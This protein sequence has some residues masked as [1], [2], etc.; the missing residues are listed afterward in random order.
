MC[1]DDGIIVDDIIQWKQQNFNPC[2]TSFYIQRNINIGVACEWRQLK[3]DKYDMIRFIDKKIQ[4]QKAGEWLK[5]FKGVSIN[6][7]YDWIECFDDEQDAFSW[8]TFF[9]KHNNGIERSAYISKFI[10]HISKTWKDS[11]FTQIDAFLW[12]TYDFTSNDAIAYNKLDI[13]VIT[14]R[15]LCD[16]KFSPTTTK[17]WM[18]SGFTISEMIQ[19]NRHCKLNDLTIT[20]KEIGVHPEIAGKIIS[21]NL[22]TENT[23]KIG[24]A[25]FNGIITVDD[26]PQMMKTYK[27][28]LKYN[29]S[30]SSVDPV[31]IYAIFCLFVGML[32][33]CF[34]KQLIRYLPLY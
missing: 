15:K 14:A 24:Q 18:A 32:L 16:Q 25:I 3:L 6:I 21:Y 19:W 13:D 4:P 23:R 5:L 33:L 10:P 17:E 8:Y 7:L 9:D 28:N 27:K 22:N 29:G 20:L 2:Y 11:G 26:V 1:E 12:I 34:T 31:I 30:L